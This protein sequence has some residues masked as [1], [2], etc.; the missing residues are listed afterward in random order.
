MTGDHQ[1]R[2]TD[3][4]ALL[5]LGNSN[6]KSVIA[7]DETSPTLLGVRGGHGDVP[8]LLLGD[9]QPPNRQPDQNCRGG[10]CPTITAHISK[11]SADGPLVL[12]RADE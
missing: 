3:Y 11:V 7:T 1:N 5:V 10:G 4:T 12:I 6:S 9:R 2:I 8:I